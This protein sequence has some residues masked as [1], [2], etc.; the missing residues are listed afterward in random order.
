M[1]AISREF[2]HSSVESYRL[3]ENKECS[4]KDMY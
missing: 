1:K 2:E 4:E 3:Q